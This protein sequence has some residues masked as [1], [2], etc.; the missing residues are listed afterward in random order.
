MRL[1]V[2]QPTISSEQ[3]LGIEHAAGFPNAGSHWL[4]VSSR[5]FEAHDGRGR[6]VVPE[7]VAPDQAVTSF[8]RHGSSAK[9]GPIFADHDEVF[10]R[11]DV[12]RIDGDI[13]INPDN[14]DAGKD[15]VMVCED[16]TGF[17][18][19]AMANKGRDGLIWRYDLRDNYAATPIVG[20]K[21]PGRDG[22]PVTSGVWETSGVLDAEHLFGR[23]S[24]L[25]DVQAHPP[26]TAPAPNTVEDGQLLLLLPTH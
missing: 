6:V 13:A 21:T 20:L 2:E 16:G 8:I 5:R 11:I 14:I 23:N 15:F 25:F 12:V 22:K 26:T 3:M 9:A 7:I 24:W 19:T 10:A 18:R 4:A 1:H 17:G